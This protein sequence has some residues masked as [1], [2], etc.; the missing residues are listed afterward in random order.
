[1]RASFESGVLPENTPTLKLHKIMKHPFRTT[2]LKLATISAIAFTLALT[3]CNESDD[4]TAGTT[5]GYPLTTCVVSDE[6]LGSMGEPIVINHEGTKVKLC[7]KSCIDDF[8]ADP[9]PFLAKLAS[10]SAN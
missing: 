2:L 7:C 1:M 3:S 10:A 4:S 5:D 8:N 9:A 6:P